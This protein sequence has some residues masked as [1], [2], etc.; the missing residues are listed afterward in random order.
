MHLLD[1]IYVDDIVIA[2]SD[3]HDIF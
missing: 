3:N 2:R 1:N